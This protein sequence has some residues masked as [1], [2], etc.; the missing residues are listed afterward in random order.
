MAAASPLLRDT[1]QTLWLASRLLVTLDKRRKLAAG[2]VPARIYVASGELQEIV[3]A[4]F[5][6]LHGYFIIGGRVTMISGSKNL[7]P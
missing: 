2:D 4:P 3:R 5:K 7:G 6:S 1:E